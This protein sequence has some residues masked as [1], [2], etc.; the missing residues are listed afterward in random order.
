MNTTNILFSGCSWAKGEGLEQL[1]NDENNMCN[2]FA[3]EYFKENYRCSNISR[4]GQSNLSI[5]I[6][7]VQELSKNHY[8]Y[9][10]VCWTAYPRYN[11]QMG[12][13]P[14]MFN[15]RAYF[16][17]APSQLEHRG[18]KMWFSTTWFN[19][20]KDK[21]M[22]IHHD[23][24]EV[25]AIIE[26]IGILE[27][28]SQKIGT[29]IYYVNTLCAWDTKFFDRLDGHTPDTLFENLTR[30]S[31]DVLDA[32]TRSRQETFDLYR[33]MHDHFEELGGIRPAK[34]IN[35]YPSLG[36]LWLAHYD[37][38]SDSSSDWKVKIDIGI[39]NWQPGHP[40]VDHPGP[41]SYRRFGTYLAQHFKE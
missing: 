18:H 2:V 36:R 15:H 24:F 10:F 39:D 14:D 5:F 7:T 37:P 16:T 41:L 40:Q 9:A 22:L 34:W 8:D 26:Y 1:K 17:G 27:T 29:K 11:F 32:N 33:L 35:L 4:G 19:D 23:H 20:F 31:R 12:F 6:D 38:K 13:E 25:C 28:L 21:Y 30:K 3:K